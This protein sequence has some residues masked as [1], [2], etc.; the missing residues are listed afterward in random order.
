MGPSRVS[1]SSERF[2]WATWV[3]VVL[4]TI[5]FSIYIVDRPLAEFAAF[6]RLHIRGIKFLI[7]IPGLLLGAAL[8]VPI[9]GR[10]LRVPASGWWIVATACSSAILWTAAAVELVLKPVFGR[11]GPYSWL[12]QNEFA[13]HWLRGR[14]TEFQS[15]PSG[16]A[17][18]LTAT[19]AVFWVTSPRWRWVYLLIGGLEAI[20][21]VW[22][23]WH[24]ASDVV[25]GAAIGAVGAALAVSCAEKYAKR[26]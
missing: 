7:G 26:S 24:F 8:V 11:S 6:H 23:N 18:V 16:E 12:E 5:L 13:F 3:V 15:M 25:A 10:I 22:F 1:P 9:V 2:R 17:A 21:L 4:G 14:A 20:S 19:L